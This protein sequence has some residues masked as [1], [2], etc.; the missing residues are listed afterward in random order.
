[1][2]ACDPALSELPELFVGQQPMGSAELHFRDLPAHTGIR[3]Q[4]L[5]K[6]L[7]L[8]PSSGGDYRETVNSPLTVMSAL[9]QYRAAVEERVFLRAGV[10]VGALGAEAAV[11]AA[12]PAF[13]VD[14]AA[15]VNV[16]SAELFSYPVRP[17]AK[18]VYV[19]AYQN[20]HVVGAVKPLPGDD[21][22]RQLR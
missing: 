19:S 22:L 21:I 12:A 7:A 16:L 1:M 17:G 15:Q 8:Q 3:L 4:S 6:V 5:F 18:L 13:S 14:D 11:L 2:I 20:A 10:I 9:R